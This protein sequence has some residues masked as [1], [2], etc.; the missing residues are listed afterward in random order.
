MAG[1]ANE[2]LSESSPCEN[3]TGWRRRLHEANNI[4]T[5]VVAAVIA[6]LVSLAVIQ[7]APVGV[8]PASAVTDAAACPSSTTPSMDPS[9]VSRIC[10]CQDP[11]AKPLVARGGNEASQSQQAC[12]GE[13]C[14]MSHVASNPLNNVAAFSADCHI[15]RCVVMSSRQAELLPLHTWSPQLMYYHLHVSKTGGT[16]FMR[17]VRVRMRVQV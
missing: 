7:A 1:K 13:R 4:S 12:I 16:T 8:D 11:A 15:C 14:H 6:V 9:R 2:V 5:S 17:Y 10:L 3:L